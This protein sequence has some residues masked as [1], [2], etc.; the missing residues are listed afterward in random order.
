MNPG[1]DLP[2]RLGVAAVLIALAFAALWLGGV[3]F[4]IVVCVAGILMIGE[5]AGLAGATCQ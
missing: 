3:G 2:T 1:S 4:W 5:W